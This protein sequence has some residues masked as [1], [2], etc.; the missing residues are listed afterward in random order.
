LTELLT[1]FSEVRLAASAAPLLVI[2]SSKDYTYLDEF[3]GPT[4]R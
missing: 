1:E 4:R 3:S 2:E